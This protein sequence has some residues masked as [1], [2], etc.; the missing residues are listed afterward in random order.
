M[1]GDFILF[2]KFMFGYKF[3]NAKIPSRF[4]VSPEPLPVRKILAILGYYQKSYHYCFS[5]GG[6][7]NF[8]KEN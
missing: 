3:C 4:L 7:Q 8:A 1:I 2:F 5:L 6:L